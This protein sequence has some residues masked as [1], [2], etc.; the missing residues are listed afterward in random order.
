MGR[1]RP[2]LRGC[3]AAFRL[4]RLWRPSPGFRPKLRSNS[5]PEPPSISSWRRTVSAAASSPGRDPHALRSLRGGRHSL[6]LPRRPVRSRAGCDAVGIPVGDTVSPVPFFG[7][8]L[9][10]EMCS[11]WG[12]SSR[13]PSPQSLGSRET[14]ETAASKG[15]DAAA[16]RGGWHWQRTSIF[17]PRIRRGSRRMKGS[18]VGSRES[19]DG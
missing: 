11:L 13:P 12:P 14:A 6:Q 10:T 16:I 8:P 17:T 7:R 15:P 5:R 4:P 19:A 3:P 1:A 18:R 2:L 9:Q